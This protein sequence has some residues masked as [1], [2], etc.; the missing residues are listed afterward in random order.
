[1]NTPHP[2][3]VPAAVEVT[4]HSLDSSVT[5]ARIYL[6]SVCLLCKAT[7]HRGFGE[8]LSKESPLLNTF[9]MET[10]LLCLL[11]AR[12]CAG[13]HRSARRQGPMRLRV[14]VHAAWG[15]ALLPQARAR[16]T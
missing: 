13:L 11:S 15:A 2:D 3:V 16:P 8:G 12:S 4:G 7:G 1:M 9:E 5:G 6:A 14:S 10:K